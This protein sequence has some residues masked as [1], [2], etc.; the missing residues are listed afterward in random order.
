[1]FGFY[2]GPGSKVSSPDRVF[3][4]SRRQVRRAPD[5]ICFLVVSK[6]QCRRKDFQMF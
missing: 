2:D 6:D 3:C 4:E 5:L 1:M